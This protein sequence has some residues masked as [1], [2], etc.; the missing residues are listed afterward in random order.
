M[1]QVI[2]TGKCVTSYYVIPPHRSLLVYI[3][4]PLRVRVPRLGVADL[5][6]TLLDKSK[7]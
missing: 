5:I 2:T 1:D 4:L 3:T 6:A 7:H